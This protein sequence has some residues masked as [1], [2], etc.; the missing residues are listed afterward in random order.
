MRS[1]HTLHGLQRERL[2]ETARALMPARQKSFGLA[3]TLRFILPV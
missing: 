1:A 2:P 3:E